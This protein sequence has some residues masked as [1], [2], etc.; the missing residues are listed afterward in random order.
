M[1]RVDRRGDAAWVILARPDA[2]NALSV[3]LV[4]EL[5]STMAAVVCDSTVRA[6]V[7]T[8]TGKAF[9]AGADLKERKGMSLAETRAFLDLLNET[10]SEIAAARC[11]VIAALNGAAFGGGLELALACDLRVAAESATMGLTE[12]RLGII[13]GAGGTQRLARLIGLAR[14]KELIFT[15]RRLDA[16]TAHALGV[17]SHVVPA[18]GL[19]VAAQRL[20]DE[21]A[22]G[23]PLAVAAA[24]AAIDDG[25]ALD[26]P[27]ALSLERRHYETILQTADRD[28]GLRAFAEKRPPVFTGK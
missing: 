1:I 27:A 6:I 3:A 8:G 25:A 23:G 5:R 13:P 19:D 20:A 12:V 17:V 22:A 4:T 16:L 11:P 9:C 2:A 7:L 18:A 10:L 21:I 24:K 28:E 14:A 26:L 15:G